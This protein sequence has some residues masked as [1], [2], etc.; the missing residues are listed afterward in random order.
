MSSI[1]RPA[2]RAQDR[3]LMS[4]RL[5]MEPALVWMATYRCM[6]EAE[7]R[8]GKRA[9]AHKR[10]PYAHSTTDA[11]HSNVICNRPKKKQINK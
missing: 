2:R 5:L 1:K 3:Q 6:S 11:T 4:S 7:R 9:P 8:M 10:E